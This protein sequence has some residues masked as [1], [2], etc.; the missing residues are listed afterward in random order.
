MTNEPATP[1][2]NF[3]LEAIEEDLH[4]GRFQAVQTRFP[5]EPNG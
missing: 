1:S 2:S 4:S 3:I 5:P